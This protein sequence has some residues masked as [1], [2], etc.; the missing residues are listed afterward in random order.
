MLTA[1][2]S[3]LVEQNHNLIYH[4]INAHD[5]TID[6]YYDILAIALCKAAEAYDPSKGVCFSTFTYRCFYNACSLYR[7]DEMASK[8]I[9]QHMM[10][11]YDAPVENSAGQ[12]SH[13]LID[14]I[15]YAKYRHGFEYSDVLIEQF[16]K[17][18]TDKQCEVLVCRLRGEKGVDIAEHVG[19]TP[20]AVS[21]TR[22]Q[23]KKRWK[24]F[25]EA[26]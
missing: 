23:I 11:Y 14:V 10:V 15:S 24:K 4:Y 12:E 6:E 22:K 3:M 26:A 9:P 7:R 20:Q 1:E 19:C 25:C 5:L 8:R 2:Q 18:L 21:I 16:M 17:H 13:E